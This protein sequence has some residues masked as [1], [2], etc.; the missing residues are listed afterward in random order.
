MSGSCSMTGK[1]SDRQTK[2]VGSISFK[3]NFLSRRQLVAP[4]KNIPRNC[5]I[6]RHGPVQILSTRPQ[7]AHK[8]RWQ[9]LGYIVARLLG[10]GCVAAFIWT[11]SG[12]EV[13]G[14]LYLN[15]KIIHPA[16]MMMRIWLTSRVYTFYVPTGCMRST[17]LS[18]FCEDLL[19]VLRTK[20][21]LQS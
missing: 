19:K 5:F 15:W 20:W 2:G 18:H 11:K 21:N 10:G 6:L 9:Y 4:T 16:N 13:V 14:F 12:T 1:A 7:G 3:R 8:R 17:T